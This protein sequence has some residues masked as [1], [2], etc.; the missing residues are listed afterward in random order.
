MRCRIKSL[1]LHYILD[2]LS[3][4]K[5]TFI[6]FIVTCCTIALRV[7]L[8]TI[9]YHS[10]FTSLLSCVPATFRTVCSFEAPFSLSLIDDMSS[11]VELYVDLM[12]AFFDMI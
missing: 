10:C 8:K 1:Y 6:L 7:S 5:L 4:S 3:L 2:T 11:C 12:G 9:V